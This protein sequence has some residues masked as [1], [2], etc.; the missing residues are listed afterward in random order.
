MKSDTPQGRTL[1][2]I[3][4]HTTICVVILLCVLVLLYVS[5]YYYMCPHTTVS[6]LVLLYL[7]SYCYMCP[8]TTIC[9]YSMC[10]RTTTCVLI[11]KKKVLKLALI[12]VSAYS[13]VVD[14]ALESLGSLID[15]FTRA[16]CAIIFFMCTHFY[17]RARSGCVDRVHMYISWISHTESALIEIFLG[18][19]FLEIFFHTPLSAMFPHTNICVRR[20]LYISWISNTESVLIEI[21]FFRGHVPCIPR[22]PQ[23]ILTLYLLYLLYCK[24]AGHALLALLNLR[25]ANAAGG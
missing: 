8:F 17:T 25:R 3:F 22:S 5:S 1:L 21:F 4:P 9:P 12:N 24:T 10:P 19:F 15:M 7:S 11:K 20:P 18:I 13:I 6:V 14:H 16:V 2:Y 23:E